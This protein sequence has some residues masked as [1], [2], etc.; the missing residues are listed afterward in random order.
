[1]C[2]ELISYK[3]AHQFVYHS[4]GRFSLENQ[5]IANAKNNNRKETPVSHS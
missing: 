3:A 5:R 4:G 1:M 2:G